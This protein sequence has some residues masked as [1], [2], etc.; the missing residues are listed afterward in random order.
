VPLPGPAGKVRLLPRRCGVAASLRTQT[1][2]TCV[3][4][5]AVVYPPGHGVEDSLS[6]RGVTSTDSADCAICANGAFVPYVAEDWRLELL[7]R[8]VIGEASLF[9]GDCHGLSSQ[10]ALHVNTC[11]AMRNGAAVFFATLG[12]SLVTG[13]V[14]GSEPN[15]DFNDAG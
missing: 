12:M 5:F 4:W 2:H 1:T 7:G 9:A 14:L 6:R 15:D 8:G 11:A 10:M 13:C 3:Q